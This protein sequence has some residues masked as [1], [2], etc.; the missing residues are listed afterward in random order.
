M[1]RVHDN[2]SPRYPEFRSLAEDLGKWAVARVKSRQEKAFAHALADAAIPYYLPLVEKRVRRRDNGKVRKS[3]MPL[4]P[5]YVALALERDDWSRAYLTHRVADLCPVDDQHLFVRELTQIQRTIDS[6][7]Q[8]VLAPVFTPGQPV[9]VK[10]GP[11]MGL[12]GEVASA[13][14]Q[15]MFVIWVRMFQQ[16]VRIELDE[17]DLETA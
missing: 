9:R 11:L 6:G 12:E 10:S 14:G 17:M 3:L 15:T 13:K 8:V 7:V 16:A 4:F 5:G 1:I 2:P